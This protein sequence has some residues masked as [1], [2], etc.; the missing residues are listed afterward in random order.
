MDLN[1]YQISNKVSFAAR[2]IPRH[3]VKGFVRDLQ[4][5]EKIDIYVHAA[6][7]EDTINSAQVFYNWI[8]KMGKN[9]SI[10]ANPR[11]LKGL[12][13][14]HKNK[15]KIKNDSK[16]ADLALVLDFNSE[17]R[18]S[19]TFSKKLKQ[20]KKIIGLDHHHTVD[21]GIR[22]HLYIDNKAASCCGLV[23]RFFEGLGSKLKK[24]DLQ[25]LY[26]GMISDYKKSKL[27]D[28]K[29]KH[30]SIEI[31]K[32]PAFFED[33]NSKEVFEKV[34]AKLN[35]KSRSKVYKHLNIIGNLTS[36][37]S[38]F[39]EKSISKVQVTPNGKLAYLVIEPHDRDWAL[40]GMDNNRTSAIISDIRSRL[41]ANNKNDK[42]I[43]K[44][45]KNKLKDVE[46]AIVFYRTS[47]SP[48]SEYRMSITSKGDYAQRLI[49][50]IQTNITP[51]LIAGGHPN[52]AGGKITTFKKEE[53]DKFVG[54]FLIAASKLG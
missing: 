36:K 13:L 1:N 7:D 31:I 16:S 27:I 29:T 46:G 10:C 12:F 4:R 6:P 17:S 35:K 47:V 28:I 48:K 50:Y 9:V 2:P 25:K 49:N 24:S 20:S 37:E 30:N 8:K 18:I 53:V 39:R 44:E 11:E 45:L 15:Y 41:I 54:N 26:C 34:E 22:K 32:L 43:T 52:R 5:A 42:S 21:D 40:I 19:N 38:A 33:K 3:V 14:K 23:Y 51:N